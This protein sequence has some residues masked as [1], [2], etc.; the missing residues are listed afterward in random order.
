MAP[1]PLSTAPSTSKSYPKTTPPSILLVIIDIHPLSWSLLASPPPLAPLPDHPG[2]DRAQASPMTLPDF[3]T[4]LMVFLNAHLASRWGNEVVVYG[5]SAGRAK[6]LYPPPPNAVAGPSKPRPNSYLP[7][8]LLDSRIEEGLKEMA[9]EERDRLENG[10]IKSL[11]QPPAMV[12]ALTKALCFINRIIPNNANSA[13]L[14]DPTSNQDQN[15][16]SSSGPDK[17][18][19]RILVINATPGENVSTAQ[20]DSNG[21][22]GNNANA[23]GQNNGESSQSGKGGQMRGG[24]VGL[25]NCVFAAQKAKVPIDVLSLPP[26]NIDASP[27]IFLQQAA[28]LTEGIYWQ[29]NGRGGLLQYLHALY[30]PPPSL[31][32]HP[33]VVPPQDAVGFRAVCFCHHKTLDVGFVCSVCLSIFCEPRPVCLMCK[34]RFPIK[35]IPT[36]KSLAT[37]IEPIPIPDTVPPLPVQKGSWNNQA[38]DHKKEKHKNATN[39][40]RSEPIEID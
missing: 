29:W 3:V 39:G 8:Q 16:P 37:Y 15:G 18:E 4:V 22:N 31:R 27:P 9:A 34:T 13:A 23:N 17:P 38:A 21:E 40:D 25:M 28:H 12:S 1:A 11:N 36:L 30:L 26:P 7:F 6:L 5:A 24:Y 35:S 2:I 19:T 32:H 20:A 33:F 10:D 14:I